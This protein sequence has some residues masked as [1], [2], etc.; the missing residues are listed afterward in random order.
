[1]IENAVIKFS[2]GNETKVDAVRFKQGGWVAVRSNDRWVYYP[3]RHIG[4]VV[5]SPDLEEA[6]E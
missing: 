3:P 5:T 1:M 6:E 2:N 4:R